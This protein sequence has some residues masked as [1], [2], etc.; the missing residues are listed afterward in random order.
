MQADIPLHVHREDQQMVSE[1][2][3][4]KVI[5]DELN[6][7]G[8]FMLTFRFVKNE[9]SMYVAMKIMRMKKPDD[10]LIIGLTN[11]DSQMKQRELLEKKLTN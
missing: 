10:H 9:K 11:I 7:N 5:L 6:K 3:K 8:T 1:F 4:R 2:V